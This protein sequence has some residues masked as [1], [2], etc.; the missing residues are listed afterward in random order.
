[1]PA[2]AVCNHFA[3]YLPHIKNIL[4]LGGGMGSMVQVVCERG[5]QP[6]FTVVETDKTILHWLLEFTPPQLLAC[7][8]PICSDATAF[9]VANTKKFDLVFIDVFIGRRVPDFVM[10]QPFLEHCRQAMAQG[11]HL[12]LNYIVNNAGEWS[13]ATTTFASVFPSYT[14]LDRGENR[15]LAV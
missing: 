15:I 2:I 1:M 10:S 9:M 3:A 5:I 13:D 4:V 14:V 8:D 12:A 11:G 7:I 6:R